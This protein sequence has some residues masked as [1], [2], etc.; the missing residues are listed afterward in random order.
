MGT[1]KPKERIFEVHTDVIMDKEDQVVP[2]SEGEDGRFSIIY[3]ESSAIIWQTNTASNSY[4]ETRGTDNKDVDKEQR[5]NTQKAVQNDVQNG[6]WSLRKRTAIQRMP[7]SLERIRH[8]QLLEGFDVTSFNSVM[9]D[10]PLT[11]YESRKANRILAVNQDGEV[12][13]GE[14][15]E[16]SSYN[17]VTNDVVIEDDYDT[18]GTAKNLDD[19]FNSSASDSDSSEE[20]IVRGR[21]IN[22]RTGYR[23]IMPRMAWEKE[24]SKKEERKKKK[25]KKILP[26]IAPKGLA[27]KKKSSNNYQDNE[28]INDIIVA[29]NGISEIDN[30][31]HIY[32]SQILENDLQKEL[33]DLDAYYTEKYNHDYV[34]DYDIDSDLGLSPI[35]IDIPE[36]H[37][38]YKSFTASPK[39]EDSGHRSLE[40]IDSIDVGNDEAIEETN[41]EKL[42]PSARMHSYTEHKSENKRGIHSNNRMKTKPRSKTN[43]ENTIKQRSTR[44]FLVRR[45]NYSNKNNVIPISDNG[46]RNTVAKMGKHNTPKKKLRKRTVRLVPKQTLSTNSITFN[47]VV[48]KEGTRYAM[49]NQ[50]SSH[51]LVDQN[52]GAEHNKQMVLSEEFKV[53]D[54]LNDNIQHIPPASIMLNLG[55]TNYRISRLDVNNIVSTLGNVFSFVVDQGVTDSELLN[56]NKLISEF[57][58][59]LDVPAIYPVIQKFHKEFRSKVSSYR[60]KSKPIHFLQI[61]ACQLFFLEIARYN[62]VS[63]TKRK[64]I[65]ESILNHIVSFFKLLSLC[66]ESVSK[67]EKNYLYESYNMLACIIDILKKKDKLWTLLETEQFPPHLSQIICN[68]FPRKIEMWD[69]LLLENSFVGVTNALSWVKYCLRFCGWSISEALILKF[70]QLFRKR[71]FSDF[72]EESTLSQQNRVL[73]TCESSI[74]G[75]T[76]FNQ[77][78]ALL[79]VSSTTDSLLEKVSPI[80]NLSVEDSLSVVINRFNLL[81]VLSHKSRINMEQQL[82]SLLVTLSSKSFLSK[83]DSSALSKI[84]I[85]SVNAMF[86]LLNNNHAKGLSFKGKGIICIYNMGLVKEHIWQKFIK[87]MNDNIDLVSMPNYNSIIKQLFKCFTL[88]AENDNSFIGDSL[89]QLLLRL[90]PQLDD[91]WIK[92]HLFANVKSRAQSSFFYTKCYYN[93]GRYLIEKSILNWWSFVTY[94]GL[95]DGSDEQFYFYLIVTEKNDDKSFNT[96]KQYLISNCFKQLRISNSGYFKKVFYKLLERVC[97]LKLHYPKIRDI[98]NSPASIRR[99]TKVLKSLSYNEAIIEFIKFVSSNCEGIEMEKIQEI[100]EFFNN[101]YGGDLLKDSQE[102]IMLKSKFLTNDEQ[103]D[104]AEFKAAFSKT[105]TL[106]NQIK[107]LDTSFLFSKSFELMEM[108]ILLLLDQVPSILKIL[109]KIISAHIYLTDENTSAN[110]I[111]IIIAAYYL[112]YITQHL[113]SHFGLC[114]KEDFLQLC[115]LFKLICEKNAK[116]GNMPNKGIYFCECIEFQLIMLQIAEGFSEYTQLRK[117]SDRFSQISGPFWYEHIDNDEHVPDELDITNAIVKDFLSSHDVGAFVLKIKADVNYSDSI[118][119]DKWRRFCAIIRPS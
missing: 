27:V 112:R 52:I 110:V 118:F 70:N 29:D 84:G 38:S 73:K 101:N 48:E 55:S 41:I 82:N 63:S 75:N 37:D 86:A 5:S 1:E 54:V 62:N 115:K 91:T 113:K 100:I 90:L 96:V 77:Y 67:F 33:Q 104:I 10:I 51:K 117:M 79:Q 93:I 39:S 31:A 15:Q 76:V 78:L 56:I 74:P 43:K 2:D 35:A 83:K 22:I 14:D 12:A 69:I 94:N 19:Q 81:L 49:L 80:S 17:N 95:I 102:F 26:K 116:I 25:R 3:R 47:T 109:Y 18:T 85:S 44:P 16:D 106:Q 98:L 114:S 65:E 21:K 24:I 99:I 87:K 6:R 20:M 9:N 108:R 58:I 34:S 46:I 60:E 40:F 68:I 119:N 28:L 11:E 97:G 36:F 89:L 105:L 92:T 50:K 57:L 64:E 61:A 72:W 66:Y 7:Y 103:T 53:L 88:T 30:S 71:R 13:D 45:S 111:K 4:V 42:Y 32:R 107:L 23:G 8:R 59:H